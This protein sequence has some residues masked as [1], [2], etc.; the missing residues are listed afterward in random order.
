[1]LLGLRGDQH[2]QSLGSHLISE[3]RA[4]DTLAV[5]LGDPHHLL[6]DLFQT[7]GKKNGRYSSS[8]SDLYISLRAFPKSL[9]AGVGRPENSFYL[10]LSDDKLGPIP[11]KF[12]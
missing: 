2:H 9:M 11:I 1:M 6:V 7:V 8:F 3:T 10:S 4:P 12:N 5:H